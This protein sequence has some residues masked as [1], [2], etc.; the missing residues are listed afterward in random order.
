MEPGQIQK[1]MEHPIKDCAI[2]QWL[3][4]KIV[5]Y[6]ERAIEVK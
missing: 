3:G 1:I 5:K 2:M 4:A 6:K